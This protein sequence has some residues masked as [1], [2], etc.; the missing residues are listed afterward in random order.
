MT[1]LTTTTNLDSF[2]VSKKDTSEEVDIVETD[3]GSGRDADE[4]SASVIG[5]VVT[6]ALAYRGVSTNRRPPPP[7]AFVLYSPPLLYSSH[8]SH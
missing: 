6:E 4:P 2:V 8:L 1:Y 3:C 5:A 7:I